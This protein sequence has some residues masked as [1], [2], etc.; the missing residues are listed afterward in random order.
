MDGDRLKVYGVWCLG[1]RVAT[2]EG[3]GLRVKEVGYSGV[4]N[5]G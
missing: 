3:L 4:S 5:Q 1:L 2:S